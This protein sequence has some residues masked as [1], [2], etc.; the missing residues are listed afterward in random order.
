MGKK[1]KERTKKLKTTKRVV[2]L[3]D[4]RKELGTMIQ[5]EANEA[6]T[7]MTTKKK[8]GTSAIIIDTNHNNHTSTSA[9]DTNQANMLTETTTTEQQQN[10]KELRLSAK[11]RAFNWAQDRNYVVNP[12][13]KTT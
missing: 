12:T 11:A 2:G 6:A 13:K 9:V 10:K 5:P 7:G 4:S 8:M 3:H 1:K